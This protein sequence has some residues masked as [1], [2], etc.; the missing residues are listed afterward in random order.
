MKFHSKRLI[1][2]LLSLISLGSCKNSGSPQSV[3]EKFL[4][5]FSQMDYETAKSLSTKDTWGLLNAMANY[6]DALP[7]SR[8]AVLTAGFKIK[9][10]DI[11]KESDSTAL[12]S[13]HITQNGKTKSLPFNKLRMVRQTDR[14]GHTRWK[15]AIS[16]LDLIERSNLLPEPENVFQNGSTTEGDSASES[17]S[18]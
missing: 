9:I 15:V 8:K 14:Y 10:T 16:T 4:S 1:L 12:I 18:E 2:V 7:A 6:T 17:T 11:Q 5:S 13:Y 3:A